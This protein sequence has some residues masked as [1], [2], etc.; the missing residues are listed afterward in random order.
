MLKRASAFLAILLT[1]VLSAF[2]QTAQ[3]SLFRVSLITCYPGKIVYELYGHSAIR[4]VHGNMDKVYNF[5]LFSFSKPNFLYRFVKGETDYSLGGYPFPYFMP[6][7][8]DRNSKVVEQWLNLSQ[9]QASELYEQLEVL[10]LPENREYRYNYVLDNCATRPRDMIEHAVGGISYPQPADT[11][12]TFRKI[13][14]SYSKNYPWY[15]FGIDLALG[16]GIDYTLD[17]RK[18]MFA[19]VYLM[20]AMSGATFVDHSGTTVPIV[21]STDTLFDGSESPILPPTPWYLSPM[22]AALACLLIIGIFTIRD[23]RRRKTTKIVDCLWFTIT[24]LTGCLLFFLIF[25]SE[26][27]ATSPNY[28][29]F[30]L[31]P[32]CFT[33]AVLIWIKS[34]RKWLY[35][36]HFINFAVV[37]ALA[38]FWWLLPQSANPAFFPLMACSI[39]RSAN[40]IAIN[41]NAKKDKSK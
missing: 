11:T 40:Y 7:Y 23:I 31:N 38:A 21:E 41:R 2:S 8:I 9:E 27:E 33:G 1:A 4:I 18:Q 19:P 29:A 6:E 15:Q 35:S 20:K 25:I 39:L 12:L 10:C 22:F 26:H 30:W 32:F 3:D 5:G 13:M 17:A 37:L 24:G 28:L 16:S 34:A 14:R 36:Y